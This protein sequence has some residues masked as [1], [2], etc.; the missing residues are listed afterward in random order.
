MIIYQANHKE[1]NAFYIGKTIR[2]LECRKRQHENESKHNRNGSIFYKALRK[3]GANM[4]KWTILE[5]C[6]TLE[7]LNTAEIKW[8]KLIRSTP[9]KLYNIAD[10]GNGGDVGGSKYWKKNGLRNEMKVKI[11]KSLKEYYKTHTHSCKGVNGKDST[12][13]GRKHT[14][15]AKDKV[16]KSKI[17]I[18]R[19]NECKEKLREA[20]LGKKH[21][22]ETISK[23]GFKGSKN[24]SAKK[25][26]CITTG[27]VFEYATLAAIKYNCD[28]SSIIKCC[29]GKLK[30]CKGKVYE[31]Y[32]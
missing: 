15:E 18:P 24:P 10:G 14:Q 32:K 13:Y 4:F 30:K 26:I 2:S 25:I 28:L 17:G 1:K 22:I 8:I 16:S 19:S 23:L 3:Y 12:N 5:S 20:N 29:K 7:E 9:H 11:S 27:E 31:Y 6:E 21:S